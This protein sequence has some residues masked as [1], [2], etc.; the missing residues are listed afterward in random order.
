VDVHDEQDVLFHVGAN[1]DPRRDTVIVDGPMD[2]LDHATPYQG[3]G[4]K[5]GIDATRKIPGEGLVREWP[6]EIEMSTE[7]KALVERRWRDYG[8]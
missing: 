8:L 6:D 1:C 3:A 2:I 5:M 7:I 4:S